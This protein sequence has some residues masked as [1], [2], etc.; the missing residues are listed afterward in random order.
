MST[1]P[2][3]EHGMLDRL[4][5]GEPALSDEEAVARAPYERLLGRISDLEDDAPPPGWEDR[6]M[7]RW[8][9]HRRR[10]AGILMGATAAVGA[11][12][13]LLALPCVYVKTEP[14]VTLAFAHPGGELPDDMRGDE[15]V[16][17]GEV[18]LVGDTL[19]AATRLDG[20]NVELRLYFGTQRV[21]VCSTTEAKPSP[22]CR[23]DGSWLRLDWNLVQA[24]TY[25][26][27]RVSSGSA[28]PS[29][30]GDVDRDEREATEARASWEPR[31]F[32]VKH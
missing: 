8:R 32:P 23:R 1:T 9:A 29:S 20:G 3:D 30:R 7:A 13:A 14:S 25:S 4:D 6:A 21:I 22:Y 17:K 15:G 16:A 10:R 2:D 31:E 18:G 26:L 24:G 19:K 11:A 28:I 5:A 12:V 27:V